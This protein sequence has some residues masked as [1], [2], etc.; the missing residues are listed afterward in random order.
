MEI[1]SRHDSDDIF[2]DTP[3]EMLV[4]HFSNIFTREMG[5]SLIK[6]DGQDA[7]DIESA[8][9]LDLNPSQI[10][11]IKENLTSFMEEI[12]KQH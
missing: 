4:I 1:A 2:P 3:K 11:S 5:F 9:F 7:G 8:K 12:Q 6:G 10:E